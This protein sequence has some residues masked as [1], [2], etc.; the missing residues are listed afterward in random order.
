M[1]SLIRWSATMG[2][3]GAVVTAGVGQLKAL[4]LPTEQIMQKLNPVPVFYDY[5]RERY[6]VSRFEK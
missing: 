3:L 4:A 5:R 1:K 2:L 6:S